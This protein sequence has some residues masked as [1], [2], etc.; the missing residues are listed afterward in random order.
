MRMSSKPTRSSTLLLCSTLC[1]ASLSPC[2][3][4]PNYDPNK[5]TS[6][7][8][9]DNIALVNALD[10]LCLAVGGV[11]TL[12]PPETESV[13]DCV[14][15]A[16]LDIEKALN[17]RPQGTDENGDERPAEDLVLIDHQTE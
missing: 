6:P 2:Q 12:N 14:L 16:K 1:L 13:Q 8:V 10:W 15:N 9:L 4:D 5:A 11:T 7:S 17:G 3:Q